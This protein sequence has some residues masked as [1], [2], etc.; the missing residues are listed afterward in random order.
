MH[1]NPQK[2]NASILLCVTVFWVTI[3]F[4][5][6][7]TGL[8]GFDGGYAVSFLSFFLAV[9]FG[10]ATGFY[11]NQAIKLEEMLRGR[12]LLAHWTYTPQQWSRYSKKEY[13]SEMQ[14]KQGLFLVVT[15][16]ALFFGVLF[17]VLD[18]EAGIYVFAV[19]IGL[20]GLIGFTWRFTVWQNYRQNVS[21]TAEVYIS[22]DAV[23]L[24]HRM[25]CW[26]A[27]L[28]RF[29]SAKLENKR[30]VDLAVFRFSVFSGKTGN[31]ICTVRVPV[32][33]GL[34]YEAEQVIRQVNAWNS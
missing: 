31:Q 3:I 15:A 30:D 8:D 21:G 27:P 7:L 34:K 16:F 14:E 13:A 18:P 9:T 24:N 4:V 6:T 11:Y 25:Y 23:Y 19:M 29:E 12:S 5:P 28:T 2:R 33:E 17:W 26:R 10:I 20:I 1:F 22:K 32:P